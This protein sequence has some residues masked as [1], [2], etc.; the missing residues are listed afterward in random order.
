M[1]EE[2]VLAVP[3]KAL[4]MLQASIDQRAAELDAIQKELDEIRINSLKLKNTS[5]SNTI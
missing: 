5:Q 3:L 1:Y 4:E 2:K